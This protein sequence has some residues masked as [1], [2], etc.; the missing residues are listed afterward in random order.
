MKKVKILQKI[1]KCDTETLN[2]QK[3]L[4]KQHQQT[5][6]MQGFQKPQIVKKK[7]KKGTNKQKTEKP[8]YLRNALKQSQ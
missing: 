1:A 4:E 8:H 3:L 2:D 6:G 7:K 5:C